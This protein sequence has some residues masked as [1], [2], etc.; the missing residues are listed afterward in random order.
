MPDDLFAKLRRASRNRPGFDNLVAFQKEFNSQRNHRSAAILIGTTVEDALEFNL[1]RVLAR[2]RTKPL[3]RI[4]G[5]LSDFY[6][7]ILVGFAI[8][9]YGEETF[10][11]L[12]II[13]HVRNAFAHGKGPLSFRV[14]IVGE[15]CAALRVPAL[16]PPHTVGA[17]QVPKRLAGLRR[18][19]FVANRIIHN[20]MWQNQRGPRLLATVHYPIW[21]DQRTHEIVVRA[22]PLP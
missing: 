10:H 20:L 5:P 8:G 21:V 4:N 19:R 13:R 17:D 12:E 2:G 9:I 6:G 14:P 3:F 11:N 7:K 22:K 18:F 15:V 16:L 1:L